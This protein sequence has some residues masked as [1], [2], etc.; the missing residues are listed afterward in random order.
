MAI[1]SF[2]LLRTPAIHFG[3][4]TV[5]LLGRII[6]GYGSTALLVRGKKS[7]SLMGTLSSIAQNLRDAHVQ[8]FELEISGEPSPFVIDRA[9]AENASR[10]IT[11]VVSVGGGSVI[12]AGKAISAMLPIGGNVAEYLEDVGTKI[13]PGTKVPFIAVP[14]TSGTGCE[15]T[16]N[17]VLSCVG[18]QG[19]KKSLRH[20]NFMPDV[21][22]IDP[23]LALSCPP[24]IS[25][26]CGLD[27]LSQLLESYVSIKAG[28]LT[29]MLA[30]SGIERIKDS[31]VPA[32]A[33]GALDVNIR[34][35]LAYGA[36]MSGITLANAGLCAVHGF[37]SSIGGM[38]AIPHGVVC[39][40][41]LAPTFRRTIEKLTMHKDGL[42]HLVKFAQAGEILCGKRGGTAEETCD[43]LVE[44]IE[45]YTKILKIPKLGDFGVTASAISAIVEQTDNKCNP[46]KLDKE[47]MR[48]ILME[49]L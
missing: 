42:P 29:D 27:A 40:R 20:D 2:L 31:L 24:N 45:E 11:T 6:S 13:H 33:G 1:K 23:L 18:P 32:C 10:S 28:I 8:F 43:M 4:H 30:T 41:L 19:F 46:V 34:A 26:A 7:L 25:A 35:N 48:K 5:E 17:A 39:G 14:T 21:A 15:A 49:S 38:F 36:L 47:D 44:K 22:I 37:A 9:V 12:D 16:K 3:P